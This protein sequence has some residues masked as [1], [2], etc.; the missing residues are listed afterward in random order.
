MKDLQEAKELT[1]LFITHDLS[2]VKFISD[3]IVIMYLG[4]MMEVAPTNE[5]FDKPMHPYTRALLSSIPMPDPARKTEQI[6]LEGDIPSPVNPPQG[7][8]FHTRCPQ[9]MAICSEQEPLL[10]DREQGHG[11]ACFL[12]GS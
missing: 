6:L 11:V 3:R 2:V 7:C 10:R 5:I 1:Y 8:R 12:Y 4:K 9:A